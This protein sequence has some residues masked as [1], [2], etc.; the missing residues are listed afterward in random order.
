MNALEYNNQTYSIHTVSQTN[1][2]NNAN[3][4]ENIGICD[5]NIISI[6]F[7]NISYSILSEDY[8]LG[9]FLTQLNNTNNVYSSIIFDLT[10]G[11]NEDIIIEKEYDLTKSI[12]LSLL[13]TN[14]NHYMPGLTMK[15]VNTVFQFIKVS[16]PIIEHVFLYVAK[17]SNNPRAVNFYRKIGFQYLENDNPFVMYLNLN[18]MSMAKGG[19]QRKQYKESQRR[20]DYQRKEDIININLHLINDLHKIYVCSYG[21][22][23]IYRIEMKIN[24]NVY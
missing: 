9:F 6:G 19:K 18:E 5:R 12:E 17:G 8:G 7:E 2:V 16:N 21:F 4:I 15:F 3:W 1:Y 24:E 22:Y 11:K 20:E 10:C 23:V 14:M 13:C